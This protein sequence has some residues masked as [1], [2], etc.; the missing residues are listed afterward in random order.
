[1]KNKLSFLADENFSPALSGTRFVVFLSDNYVIRFRDDNPSL[2]L[3]ETRLL[4][5]LEN[6][7]IPK[8]VWQGEISGKVVMVEKRLPGET[9]DTLWRDVSLENK[10]KI[11]EEIYQFL[12]WL[13]K[14]T[15]KETISIN[16]GHLYPDF[17]SFLS[18]DIENKLREI[19]VWAES[20]DIVSAIKEIFADK[21]LAEMFNTKPTLVHGD[22][23]IHNLLS[24]GNNLSGVLDW[25]F[26]LYGDA[27]YDIARIYYYN[28][29]AKAYVD[30]D[31][32]KTFE[33]DFTQR[34]IKKI[35]DSGLILEPD[36]FRE[37]YKVLRAFFFLN[38]LLWAARSE[39]PSK[40]IEEL[41]SKWFSSPVK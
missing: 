18:E 36:K 35:N 12:L 32:D 2:L 41:G 8:V 37:K 19:S 6:P 39:E 23:I 38:A 40:N 9:L 5:K 28:E 33:A 10:D 26:S 30:L 29:C 25:E 24:S 7:I 16:T 34:L 17:Y 27:D 31:E 21:N 22:L 20:S 11:L 13:R 4:G 14:Q 1:M 15:S 3:R